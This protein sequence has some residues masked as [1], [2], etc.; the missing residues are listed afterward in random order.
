[1]A[2]NEV[3]FCDLIIFYISH[4]E[5]N[6]SK[7]LNSLCVVAVLQENI[8]ARKLVAFARW[9]MRLADAAGVPCEV[10]FWIDYSCCEQERGNGNW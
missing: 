2:A 6:Y 10:A 4:F 5:K 7:Y 1:M 3:G 8:K 9:F